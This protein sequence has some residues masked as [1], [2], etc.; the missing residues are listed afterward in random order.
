MKNRFPGYYRPSDAEFSELWTERSFVP[1]TN[2]VIGH[3]RE[4][5]IRA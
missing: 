1:D 4:T 5:T 3:P 2:I